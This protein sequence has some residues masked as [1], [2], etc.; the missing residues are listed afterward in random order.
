MKFFILLDWGDF[1]VIEIEI[2]LNFFNVDVKIAI[3]WG[4]SLEIYEIQ[5]ICQRKLATIW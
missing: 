3:K 2:Y 5:I 1:R 4:G